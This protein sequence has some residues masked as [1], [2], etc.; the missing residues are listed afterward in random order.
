MSHPEYFRCCSG[1]LF[2]LKSVL[3]TGEFEIPMLANYIA[4]P[5]KM[6]ANQLSA[7]V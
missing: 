6:N 5:N 4:F 3:D 2:Q 7:R 1:V